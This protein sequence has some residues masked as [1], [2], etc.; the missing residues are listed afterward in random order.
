MK[1]TLCS[2]LIAGLF[3]VSVH[4]GAHD[5]PET[6]TPAPSAAA[7]AAVSGVDTGAIDAGVRA[8]DDFFRY[9]QGKWLKDVEIPSDRSSWG[10]FNDAADR[11]EGQVRTI[12]ESAAAD[13]NA[14]AGSAN[15]KMGDYYGSY[16]DQARRNTLGLAPLKTELARV[17]ALKDKRGVAALSA[18]FSRIG[19]GA[20]LDMYVGQDN[21]D[22]TRLVVSVGQSGLGLPNR[23]YFLLDDARLKDI[24]TQYQAHIE[25]MLTLAGPV[26]Y[27][28]LTLP[29]ILLV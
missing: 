27:T 19:A 18:H 1:P 22:S 2:S 21:R 3:V 23:D 7:A 15:Q 17:K 14:K 6:A 8:Q 10:A 11:V 24:R 25:K 9:S 13:K 12:I 4:A 20:P 26:S 16:V 5:G 28:H 29:T